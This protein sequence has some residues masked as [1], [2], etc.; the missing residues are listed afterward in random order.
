MTEEEGG[1]L[2][3]QK[4]TTEDKQ[5]RNKQIEQ[6]EGKTTANTGSG[7][8][9]NSESRTVVVGQGGKK[10]LEDNEELAKYIWRDEV[11]YIK[12]E[13]AQCQLALT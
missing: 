11:T 12:S 6:D 10:G 9:D 8:D 1:L 3:E 7:V 13:C 4:G 5:V 2:C